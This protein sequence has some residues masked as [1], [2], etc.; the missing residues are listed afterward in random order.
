M[1]VRVKFRVTVFVGITLGL[2]RVR[3]GPILPQSSPFAT[4]TTSFMLA[5][6]VVP[7]H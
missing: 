2:G 4:S 7:S 1:T 5:F 6:V 3:L